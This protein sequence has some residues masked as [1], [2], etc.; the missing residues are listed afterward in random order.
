M[1]MLAQRF[2]RF[3]CVLLDSDTWI[4]RANGHWRG[5]TSARRLTPAGTMEAFALP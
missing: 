5:S 2:E 4:E 1:A 3:A